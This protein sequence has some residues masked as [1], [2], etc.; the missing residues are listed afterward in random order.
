MT[1]ILVAVLVI[2]LLLPGLVMLFA[3]VLRFLLR[4]APPAPLAPPAPDDDRPHDAP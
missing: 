2:A 1:R 3:I 4:G